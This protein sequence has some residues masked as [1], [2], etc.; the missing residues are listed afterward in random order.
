MY[1]VCTY[2]LASS[3]SDKFRRRLRSADVDTCIVPRTRTRF[4]DRS[5][6]AAAPG[7]GTAC[8]RN[9]DGHFC[10][11]RDSRDGGALVTL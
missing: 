4:G 5:F 2:V 1:N 9:C 3:S 10:L 8:R 7:S 11:L 6:S